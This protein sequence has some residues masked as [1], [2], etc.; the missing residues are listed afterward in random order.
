MKPRDR[1]Y[2]LLGLGAGLLAALPTAGHAQLPR[3]A[4]KAPPPAPR[5]AVVYRALG[6]LQ[7]LGARLAAPRVLRALTA[8]GTE[9]EPNDSL[10]IADSVALGDTISGTIDPAGDVDWFGFDVAAD[11][12]IV[13]DVN[14]NRSGS[15]LDPVL[16]LFGRDTSLAYILLASSDDY[17]NTLDSHIEYHVTAGRYYAALVDYYGDGGAGYFYALSF[18]RWTPPPLG[19]GDSTHVY[20]SGLG[21]PYGFAAGA[22]GEVYV[23]DVDGQRLWRVNPGGTVSPVASLPGVYPLKA[24]ADGFGNVLVTALDTAF[25]FGAVE[26]VTPAG[27]V[28]T[29]AAGLQWVAGIT[30]GPDGDVWVLGGVNDTPTLFRYDALGVRKD[31]IDISATHAIYFAAD[32]AFSPGGVL[33]F[34]NGFD[35]IYQLVNRVPEQVI[36]AAP[37]MESLAFDRDGYLYVANGSGTVAMYSPAHAVVYDPFARTNFA[38]G[39]TM[40]LV[41]GRD[42]GGAMTSRLFAT[43]P[44]AGAML[45]MNPAGMRAPGWRIGVD[46]LTITTSS[47]PTGTMGADYAATLAVQSPPGTPTW[48]LAGGTLPPGLA[49]DAVSG[50]LTGVLQA[51]GT[52]TFT[53]RVDAGGRFGLRT[54]ALTVVTPDVSINDAANDLLA[55]APLALALRRFLDFQGNHNGRYDVGDFRAHLRA[56]GHLPA[57][58]SAR[59]DLP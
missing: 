2:V 36:A 34:S 29:F 45:E 56:Q 49:L 25:N 8:T 52:F 51:S 9:V 17:N 32:L 59:K 15:L 43:N 57:T 6:R 44:L 23:T 37:Y 19:P 31:A 12:T 5:T 14:A 22:A 47:L 16:Y 30:V 38:S 11:T 27:A 7:A 50:V 58:M 28:S 24:V 53:V 54:F 46:L 35:G 13:L 41:F 39:Y 26:R 10:A 40:A 4:A 55:G 48:S 3:P 42:A 33:H 20:A 1:W 21:A 18:S